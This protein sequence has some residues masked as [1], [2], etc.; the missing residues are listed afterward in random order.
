MS[1]AFDF[2]IQHG[3]TL[4]APEAT[5]ELQAKG[6]H[7]MTLEVDPVQNTP[8]WHHFDAQFHIL[9]GDLEFRDVAG[10]VRHACS[11]GSLVCI[12]SGLLHAEHS[13]QGYS[14]VLGTSV[15]AEEFGDPVNLPPQ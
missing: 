7:T 4:S 9:S 13:K 12:P 1:N 15:P 8:H 10:D 6:L 11:A 2:A 14:I 5:A 3:A